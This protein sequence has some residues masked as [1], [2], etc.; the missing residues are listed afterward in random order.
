MTRFVSRIKVN[1]FRWQ[2]LLILGVLPAAVGCAVPQKPGMGRALHRVEV[3][4]ERPYWIYLPPSR[5]ET[6]ERPSP[7]PHRYPLVVSLH[8]MRPF[9]DYGPHIRQW[10]EEADRYGFI[11]AAPK[12][13]ACDLLKPFPIDDPTSKTLQSD[14]QAILAIIDEVCRI[15]PADPHSV[16]VTSFSS[17][18]YVAHYM[19]NRHPDRFSCLAVF[20]SN[21][22]TKLLEPDQVSKYRDRTIAILTSENDLP[23]VSRE[24]R[25]AI[26]WYQ[27]QGF[28]RLIAQERPE[29]GHERTPEFAAQ[30]F[31][32]SVGREAVAIG[33]Q[34]ARQP[35]RST[36]NTHASNQGDLLFT[37][38][39]HDATPRRARP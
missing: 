39:A 10:Q 28:R 4:T 22:T 37:P 33:P 29:V 19:M 30:V 13:K 31:A 9:D 2:S 6:A 23:L 16:M 35:H 3:V 14:E 38:L 15:A 7:Y 17:G 25:W 32:A 5:D 1:P 20:Q 36:Q 34:P 8:G 11:V 26:D 21:F 27:D 24:S 12:L 18:G